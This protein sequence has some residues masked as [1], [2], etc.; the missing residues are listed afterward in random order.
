V[1]V[2]ISALVLLTAI[3]ACVQKR[4]QRFLLVAAGLALLLGARELLF[5]MAQPAGLAGAVVCLAAGA[6]VCMGSLEAIYRKA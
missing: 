3:G 6:V 1:H 4:D 2:V 5:F